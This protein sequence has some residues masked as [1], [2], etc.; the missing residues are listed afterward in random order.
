MK[1]CCLQQKSRMLQFEH[2]ENVKF[3][4]KLGK[5]ASKMFQMIKQEYGEGALGRSAMFRWHKLFAQGRE[6]LEDN[7][8]ISQP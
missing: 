8:R 5:S 1:G 6:N 7:E 4:Q 2:H 3:C